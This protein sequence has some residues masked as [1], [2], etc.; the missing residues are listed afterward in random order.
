VISL[1]FLTEIVAAVA[2]L[3]VQQREQDLARG[4]ARFAE[5]PLSP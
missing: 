1:V 5:E 2:Y 4:P 3:T